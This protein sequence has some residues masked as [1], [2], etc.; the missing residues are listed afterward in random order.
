MELHSDLL[1]DHF[2]ASAVSCL[3]VRLCLDQPGQLDAAAANPVWRRLLA[4]GGFCAPGALFRQTEKAREPFSLRPKLTTLST[5]WQLLA[6]SAASRRTARCMHGHWSWIVCRNECMFAA[7][8][9]FTQCRCVCLHSTAALAPGSPS[10]QFEKDCPQIVASAPCEAAL[11]SKLLLSAATSLVEKQ[12][13]L[14]A[15]YA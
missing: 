11:H 4:D 1:H 13:L 2:R 12:K 5:D 6:F 14:L 9:A 15:L 10:R 3:P 7:M 8:A